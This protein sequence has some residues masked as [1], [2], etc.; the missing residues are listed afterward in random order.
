[1]ARQLLIFVH[2]WSVTSTAT[3]G[4]LPTRLKHEAQK[5]GG[6]SLDVHH[7][8]L[9]EYVSFHDTI[10][11]E[12]I[13]RAFDGALGDM[14]A[15]YGKGRRCA[16]ITHSTGGPV[17]REWLD[18]YIVRPGDLGQCPISHLVMLAPA[19]FGS[20]LAQLG[21]GRV[22]AIRAWFDGV[23]PGQHVLDWLELGSPAACE[24]NLRWIRD[25]PVLKLTQGRNPVFP[26]VLAGDAID[27]K[28]YDHLNPYT[29][30]IGSDGVMRVAATNLNATHVVLRQPATRRGEALPSAHKRLRTLDPE[31]TR[32]AMPTA[33]KIIPGASHS[34]DS[35]GIMGSVRDNDKPNATV[36]AILECLN[37]QN[38]AGYTA[39]RKTFEAENAAH[40]AVG[41]RLEIEHVPVLPDRT[42]IHDPC[43]MVIF[44]LFDSAALRVSNVDILLTAGPGDSPDQLPRGFMIDRQANQQQPANITFYLNHAV[45]AGCPPI[46]GPDGSIVRAALT[47][48]SPYGVQIL[49]R[50]GNRFVE[51]WHAMLDSSMQDLLPLIRPNETTIVDVYLTRVVHKNVFRFTTQ[52]APPVDFKDVKPDGI[53]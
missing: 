45:L 31:L 52:L 35:M 39:L 11:V 6:P 36:T 50:H 40:Q 13:A 33:F 27:R 19:N 32:H 37:V 38:D 15:R 12:D 4:Q 48:R 53:A 41:N 14:L 43:S 16:C 47:P 8:Y 44:R 29:G 49:P 26:F 18:R 2:G 42:Y 23:E 34:G 25:Y 3:Y 20:A 28:F 1:M 7:I 10:R 46:P 51:Y 5:R 21:K 24:L 30:E 22:G 9:G 17:V